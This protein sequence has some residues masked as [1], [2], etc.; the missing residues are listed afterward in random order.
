VVD[1]VHAFVT[2][3]ATQ[4]GRKLRRYLA[5]RIRNAAD[6]S[7]LVQ[8]VFLRL[9]RID[10]H[11][12]IRN[13]EA[14]IMTIASHVL[15]QHTLRLKSAPQS[16][17]AVD[18]LVDLQTAIETDPAAQVDAQRRL[19]EIDRVLARLAPNLHATFVLHRRDGMT[20]DEISKVLG[21]SRPMV[22]KYLAKALLQCRE[23]LEPDQGERQASSRRSSDSGNRTVQV[24]GDELPSAPLQGGDH[25]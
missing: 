23:Q 16:L 11:E 5:A 4:H 10:R 25:S 1:K 19:E 18:V 9:M 13:P 6:I 3:M 12:S 24:K 22:K 2:D 21:V 17:G 7:D 14:Y 15:H 8:E 20:L